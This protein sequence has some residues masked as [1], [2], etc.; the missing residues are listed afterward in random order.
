[1]DRVGVAVVF[2]SI[3]GLGFQQVMVKLAEDIPREMTH[4]VEELD[5]QK[6][7]VTLHGIVDSIPDAQSIAQSL[8]SEPCFSDVRISRTSGQR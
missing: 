7:H 1:M 4:D 3:F 5:V 8:R 2:V 6:G